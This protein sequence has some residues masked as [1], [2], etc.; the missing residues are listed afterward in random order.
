MAK[1]RYRMQNILNVKEKLE[2]QAKNEFATARLRLDEEEEK[3]NALYAR[4]DDYLDRGRRA[5]N[6]AININELTENTYA[7]ERM[8]A[9]I[10][11]QKLE[12]KKAERELE[13]ATDRLTEAMKETKIHTRLKEK[14]FEEFKKELN[15]EEAKEID[16]LTSYR[17]GQRKDGNV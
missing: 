17:Y 1:F 7:L 16:E 6:S 14:A 11:D 15:S 12:V 10:A 2:T 13:K 8:D 5:R 9:Y 4:K 3:L